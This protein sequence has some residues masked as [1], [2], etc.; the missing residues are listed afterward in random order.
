MIPDVFPY[1][2]LIIFKSFPT[3]INPNPCASFPQQGSGC[4]HLAAREGHSAIAALLLE[5]QAQLL[6]T[7]RSGRTCLHIACEHSH[8]DTIRVILARAKEAAQTRERQNRDHGSHSPSRRRSP[9]RGDKSPNN[10]Q[11]MKEFLAFVK[12]PDGL[13]RNAFHLSCCGESVRA[14]ELMLACH[15]LL[16]E[17]TDRHKRSGLFYAV[18]SGAGM[19]GGGS[20]GGSAENNA[21]TAGTS[22][23]EVIAQ[24]LLD[25]NAQPS[26]R[27][28][29]QKTPLHYACEENRAGCVMLLLRYRA[30]PS[31]Q[32]NVKRETPLQVC[33]SEVLKRQVRKFLGLPMD[34]SGGDVGVSNAADQRS[35]PKSG[36]TQ[37]V[38]PGIG[39]ASLGGS[40]G[41]TPQLMS[42][43]NKVM[44]ADDEY[45]QDVIVQSAPPAQ[46][47]TQTAGA[48]AGSGAGGAM[49]WQ[50]ENAL[51]NRNNDAISKAPVG[52]GVTFSQLRDRFIR[53]MTRVQEGG[54]QGMEHI[55][56]PHLFT[57]SWMQDVSS[58]QQLLSLTLG[59]VSGAEVCIRVFNLLRPPTHFPAARGDERDIV[60]HY[61]QTSFG[62]GGMMGGGKIFWATMIR[63]TSFGGG[64]MMGGGKMEFKGKEMIRNTEH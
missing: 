2:I 19:A 16:L 24:K 21:V 10:Q 57:G 61:R 7:D 35:V 27:D 5:Y 28:A 20:A 29:W 34:G 53:M 8:V 50:D 41:P 55:K 23:G 51:N 47:N 63:Q 48:G 42:A 56:Q 22:P 40:A 30:D 18:L 58:H 59:N 6:D 33:K 26:F 43:S 38:L 14:V 54:I 4:V 31:A 17:S 9:N 62:G 46:S 44:G 3:S 1:S 25:L 52:L 36:R 12:K 49:Q 37:G 39:G 60:D 32:D 11:F 64:G 45:A 13:G 15:N